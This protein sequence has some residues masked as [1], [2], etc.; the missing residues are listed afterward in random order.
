MGIRR[1]L[2]PWQPSAKVVSNTMEFDYFKELKK[3][4]EEL[5]EL[6][7]KAKPKSKPRQG[8]LDERVF[9][10][11][12]KLRPEWEARKVKVKTKL[13]WEWIFVNKETREEIDEVDMFRQ[14]RNL[15]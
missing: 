3:M 13:G 11:E 15:Q 7:Q 9:T 5:E 8:T 2:M 12:W 4:N 6:H 14:R 10:R 1:V